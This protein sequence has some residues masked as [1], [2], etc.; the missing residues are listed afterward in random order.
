MQTRGRQLVVCL[1]FS[2]FWE[3]ALFVEGEESNPLD[4]SNKYPGAMG[5][6]GFVTETG[7]L[8]RP[9]PAA[10]MIGSERLSLWFD[11]A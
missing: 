7:S 3:S 1:L 8:S 11:L 10:S 5:T 2:R 6:A 9:E 4:I